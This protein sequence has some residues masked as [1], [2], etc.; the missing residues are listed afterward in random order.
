MKVALVVATQFIAGSAPVALAAE[1]QPIKSV[2]VGNGHIYLESTGDEWSPT[3]AEDGNLYTNNDA[4]VAEPVRKFCL[5]Q[6]QR[7]AKPHIFGEFG[8][9]SHATTA[10]KD[11]KGWGVHNSLWSG[12]TSF[13]AGGPMPWWHESYIDK[14]DLYFHFTALANFTKGLPLGTAKWS[15]LETGTPQYLD[16]KRKPELRDAVV[17][18]LARIHALLDSGQRSRL[19]YLIR[20]GTLSL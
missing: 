4:N 18:A 5:H 12:L 14:L 16:P 10:D 9:R 2:T 19:A 7:F 20:T 1:S 3:W 13:S 6:W 8:I 11:P 17:T 15:P